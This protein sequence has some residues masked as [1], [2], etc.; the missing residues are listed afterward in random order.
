MGVRMPRTPYP[1]AK[2]ENKNYPYF[3]ERQRLWRGVVVDRRMP[4]PPPPPTPHPSYNKR[5]IYSN[6]LII[7]S[8]SVSLQ[9][10]L[11]SRVQNFP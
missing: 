11:K 9:I 7:I 2:K 4:A 3:L 5:E 8:N 10:Q 1:H 6:F